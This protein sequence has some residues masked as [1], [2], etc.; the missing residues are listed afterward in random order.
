MVKG[1]S[2]SNGGKTFGNVFAFNGESAYEIHSV[3]VLGEKATS[4]E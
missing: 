3:K 2:S 4:F 1:I